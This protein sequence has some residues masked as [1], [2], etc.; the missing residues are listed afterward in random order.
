MD[1][2]AYSTPALLLLAATSFILLFSRDWRLVIFALGI[3]YISV[4]LLVGATWPLE[5]SVIKLVAG[6]ISAAVLGMELV[7][8]A[9]YRKLAQDIQPAQMGMSVRLF[10]LLL[11][12]L[13]SLAVYSLVPEVGKWMI[14]V[15]YSQLL[16][17][18]ALMSMGILQLTLTEQP[19]RVTIGL[20]TFISGFEILYAA[21]ETSSLV[22]GFLALLSLSVALIGAY[23][24]AA[25][26]LEV[27]P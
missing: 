18:M 12:V 1:F 9:T 20:L 3:Q 5:M 6:W 11:A 27:D 4:F 19:F 21:V 8:I 23:L 25:P 14:N 24:V 15:S 17:S 2:S 7:S 16:G 22:A 26:G 10:R 13:I